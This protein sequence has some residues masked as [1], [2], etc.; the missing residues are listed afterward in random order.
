M[1]NRGLT[2]AAIA[3]SFVICTGASRDSTAQVAVSNVQQNRFLPSG[4]PVDR[5][6]GDP[7]VTST[8]TNTA[9]AA[10][11]AR[12]AATEPISGGPFREAPAAFDNKTNG[13]DNQ[14][15]NYDALTEDTV[16]ALRSFN[17]NRFIFEEVE[18][19]ADGLGPTYNAQSCRECHQ[20][21]VTGGASQVAEHRTGRMDLLQFVE[22]VGGSLIQSRSTNADIF[23]RVPFEDSVST[24]RIS[25]NTLGAGFI[26]AIA[27]DTLLKLRD[28]QPAAIRGTAQM[29]AVLEANNA[30]R[31]GRFGWKSQHASLESFAADAYLNEMGITT[32]L[33]PDENTSLGRNVGFGTAYDP[34]ADPE[35]DGVDLKAFANFMRATKA[36]PRGAINSQVRAGENAFNAAGCSGCHVGTIRTAA[37]G[38]RINGGA[39]RVKDAVGNKII[40]PYSDFLLHD[41][42]TGDGIPLLPGAEFAS[43]MTQIRTAPL[44]AL[45]TRNRL[46]H[47]GL[48]FTKEEA[49]ARHAGQASAAK[50]AFEALNATQRAALLAFLDSL[51]G[52][53]RYE[54]RIVVTRLPVAGQGRLAAGTSV[55]VRALHPDERLRV[56]HVARTEIA[57]VARHL[58]REVEQR[59]IRLPVR[60]RA[61]G[62][63]E[64]VG[65]C[66]RARDG[67]L[68]E[69]VSLGLRDEAEDGDQRPGQHAGLP[70]R[71][72]GHDFDPAREPLLHRA[73]AVQPVEQA[74]GEGARA[75]RRA[76]RIAQRHLLEREDHAVF[77]RLFDAHG[78]GRDLDV[79]T[80]V[81]QAHQL[82][83]REDL[84]PAA[85]RFDLVVALEF[86]V[87]RVTKTV[88]KVAEKFAPA[89]RS[90]LRRSAIAG[91]ETYR[92]ARELDHDAM[93]GRHSPGRSRWWT[94]VG[95]GG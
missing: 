52:S 80:R 31:I 29:V 58:R 18:H 55:F 66:G 61:I 39:L 70:P 68:Q 6:T 85:V 40:H 54:A 30:P 20:N 57:I 2:I 9:I 32:P 67:G 86:E 7:G 43:T 77:R 17:D 82:G 72:I 10:P 95:V 37:P 28:A 94:P 26:E 23:E 65:A 60:S 51:W 50:T 78:A 91:G 35:D 90:L 44:W 87:V 74:V 59:G 49:I 84:A 5:E 93:L 21:I 11:D 56:D 83:L 33:L 53:I 25:T 71:Q 79:F 46:M 24:L 16:V 12:A 92:Q 1:S 62:E 63:V 19:V 36:P 41:I 14:G 13:F 47:D 73:A 89:A 8:T 27:N 38:T 42:G 3:A 45:R 64:A 15:P 75:G 81:A 88:G 48:S 69:D 4:L 22:S 76:H 34:V